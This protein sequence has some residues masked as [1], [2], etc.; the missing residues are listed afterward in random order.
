M[1]SD[2]LHYLHFSRYIVLPD[3]TEV[4][5]PTARKNLW[6]YRRCCQLIWNAQ[7]LID[8]KALAALI[9]GEIA[10]TFPEANST[11]REGA[12][13]NAT[14]ATCVYAWLRSLK[15]PPLEKSGTPLSLRQ[16]D[17]YELG[18]LAL[19]DLYR[20]RAYRYGDAVLLTDDLL[21]QVASVFFLDHSCCIKLLRVAAKFSK[22]IKMTDTLSGPSINLLRPYT[23]DDL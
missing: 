7:G 21:D 19:D 18:L 1:A 15:P 23:V 4:K 6:S 3:L 2:V 12:R 22:H 8:A 20:A 5:A 13:F 11:A 16:I 10:Q 14:A 17:R 9:L